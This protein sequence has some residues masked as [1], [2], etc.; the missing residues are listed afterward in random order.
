MIEEPVS[1][2]AYCVSLLWLPLSWLVDVSRHTYLP[3]CLVS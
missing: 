3:T 1:V 2:V